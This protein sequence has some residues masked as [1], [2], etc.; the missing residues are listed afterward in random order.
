MA[1]IPTYDAPQVQ[2]NVLPGVRISDAPARSIEAAGSAIA[3]G[4]GNVANVFGDV[5]K[6]EQ[7]KS[8]RAAQMEIDNQLSAL[9]KETLHDPT[10]GLL[11]TSGKDAINVVDKF[12]PQW[13]DRQSKIIAGAPPQIRQWAQAQADNRRQQATQTLMRHS[14]LEGHKYA[15][16][17]SDAMLANAEQ[18]ATLNYLDPARVDEEAARAMV[19]A[20]TRNK[21]DGGDEATGATLRQA[22]SS[23]V[24]GAV[25][26][27]KTAEDPHQ[28]AVYL[29]TIRD[30]LTPDDLIRA[31]STLRPVLTDANAGAWLDAVIKGQPEVAGAIPAAGAA[32][33]LKQAEDIAR[34]SIG[35]TIGL[36][37]GGKAD[38]RNPNS[39]ATGAAQFIDKT[40][41]TVLTSARPD[42]VAGK[43][44]AEI[45]AMRNDPVLSR[46]MAEAYA[47]DNAR[48]L[49]QSGLPVTPQTIYMAHHFGLGGARLLLQAD[50]GTKVSAVL[51]AS[52]V[53]ANP[54]L[55]NKTVGELIANHQ[56]RAGEQAGANVP[57]PAPAGM[58]APARNADGSVNWGEV[59]KRAMEIPNPLLRDAVL[60][61][62]RSMSAIENN[63]REEA[64]KQRGMRVYQ[65]I[66]ADPSIPLARALS[67]A[68]YASVAAAG[69][70]PALES[71]RKNMIEGGQRQDDYALVDT[72]YRE[73]ALS[74]ATFGRRDIA[75]LADRLS[76]P[77]LTRL[78]D[79]QE[80]AKKPEETADWATKEQRMENLFRMSG[81]GHE[82]DAA[83]DGSK[84]KNATRDKHRGELRVAYQMALSEFIKVHTRKPTPKEDDELV[85]QTAL[86]YA[87]RRDDM[88]GTTRMDRNQTRIESGSPLPSEILAQ[89]QLTPEGR[90]QL[91]LDAAIGLYQ[92]R[93]GKVA[94][95]AFINTWIRNYR[96]GGGN[97]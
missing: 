58:V 66:N 71:Y 25:L 65:A 41:I 69:K 42:L 54:Y 89:M 28:A 67:P 5:A 21:L 20:D 97:Q 9:E 79:M 92:S 38:A 36:E 51:P 63:A 32:T 48:G 73:A 82:K 91:E 84:A 24:Y 80:K 74:P 52:V 40:W 59:E 8:N 44:R 95:Q 14:M 2:A 61:R 1:R 85:R 18:A 83:G 76:T 81:V 75:S 57:Q 55:R 62:A 45:L 39:S 23:R 50:P 15:V 27:R 12:T 87:V 96:Q 11:G 19:A 17:Q 29:E 68:D 56:Q 3:H 49:F 88:T 33:S 93:T 26:A 22:A 47:V 10:T 13:Q 31:E 43:S 90:M 46:Q 6:A 78:L 77:T 34:G 7:E 4:L 60:S 30:R 35:R 94:D 64:D 72:L 53:S 16:S 37:S 70:L 86:N